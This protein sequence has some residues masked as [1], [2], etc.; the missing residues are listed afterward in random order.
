MG[1]GGG[2]DELVDLCGQVKEK[3]G[4]TALVRVNS[5]KEPEVVCVSTHRTNIATSFTVAFS[6]SLCVRACV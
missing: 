4:K 5:P 3:G 6:K 1:G 2:V